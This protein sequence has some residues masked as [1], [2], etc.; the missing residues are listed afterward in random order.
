MTK[1]MLK[2]TQYMSQLT[3]EW[4]KRERNTEKKD[5]KRTWRDIVKKGKCSVVC[6]K[7]VLVIDRSS[8]NRYEIIFYF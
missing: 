2:L 3:R 6:S 8:S 5:L 4:M 7:E 1:M